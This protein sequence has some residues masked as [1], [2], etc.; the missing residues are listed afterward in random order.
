MRATMAMAVGM[1]IG[2]VRRTGIH[3]DKAGGER[4]RCGGIHERDVGGARWAR[5]GRRRAGGG[6]AIENGLFATLEA[7]VELS[8]ASG[9]WM[10]GG[11][12]LR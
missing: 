9:D 3:G 10:E 7:V 6:A 12:R 4:A 5:R 11:K 8:S 1:A 2:L